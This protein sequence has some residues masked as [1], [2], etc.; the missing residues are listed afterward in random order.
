[1]K[2]VYRVKE[3]FAKI[4]LHSVKHVDRNVVNFASE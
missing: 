1:M 4:A 3:Y 2:I